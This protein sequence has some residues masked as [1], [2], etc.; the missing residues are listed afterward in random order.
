MIFLDNFGLDFW[1]CDCR[2][3]IF[4]MYKHGH[5]KNE[6]TKLCVFDVN[7]STPSRALDP[8]ANTS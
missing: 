6:Q 3:Y 4:N 5:G 8:F 2:F 1:M 7:C